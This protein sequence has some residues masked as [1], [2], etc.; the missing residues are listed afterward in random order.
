MRGTSTILPAEETTAEM[1]CIAIDYG[2]KR[3][4]LAATDT[5]GRMAFPRRTLVMTT[6]DR[7]FAE[8]LAFIEEESPAAIVVGL[9]TLLDGTETLITRQVRNF[10]E[11][12][13]R[14]CDLPVYFMTEVLSSHEAEGDLREAGLN[15]REIKKVVD[16]Q[17]AVRILETFL[18]QPEHQRCMADGNA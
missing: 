3:T 12:L 2:T 17:A 16:Q 8:L 11:R 5:G 14:R 9:P 15:E 6:K 18:N 1:K 7:F 4:G 10:V 13:K